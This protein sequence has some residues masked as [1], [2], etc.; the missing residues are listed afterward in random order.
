MP[1][2]QT[3]RATPGQEGPSV[4]L[5]CIIFGLQRMGGVSNYWNKLIE[6]A[7]IS[8]RLGLRLI[9]P[10]HSLQAECPAGRYPLPLVSSERSPPQ[11]ARYLP[12]NV[13]EGT[14]VFHT[15]YYRLPGRKVHGYVVSAYDFTYERYRHGL[16]RFVH[17]KQK[18]SSI[19]HADAVLCI[20]HST[21]RDLLEYCP[22]ANPANLHVTHLG[23]DHDA[24]FPDPPAA[25]AAATTVLFVGQR[26]DYKRFD[27]AV[28]AVRQL[29]HLRLGIV[30]PPLKP[31]ER[32]TLVKALGTRWH[33][34]GP[35]R[36]Q[37]LRQLY[38]SAFAFVF[39]SDYEG[40]G[41][42]VLEAMACGCPVVAANRSSLPEVGAD[43]ALYASEQDAQ[44]YAHQL[45]R[46]EDASLRQGMIGAGIA[47][48]TSFTWSR[49]FERTLNVYLDLC[50]GR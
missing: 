17:S 42:P 6:S 27:L 13:P 15:S 24:F 40:F 49:T 1:M 26:D 35:V 22:A 8:S 14:D 23:V 11:L 34:F 38:S 46:L 20:S 37:V 30:G 5:D 25:D 18:L 2:S 21:R 45:T 36:Q 41:L 10:S 44:A 48:A 31:A 19:R 43:A 47:R 16:A 39:P 4:A 9:L 50:A 29:R 28:D 7:A 33:E 12:V 3:A 32:D